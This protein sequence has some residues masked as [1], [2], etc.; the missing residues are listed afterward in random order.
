MI[1][2]AHHFQNFRGLFRPLI[3]EEITYMDD[4]FYEIFED[5]PR[6]GPGDRKS[7]KKALSMVAGLPE[8]PEI[9]DIGCGTGKQTIDLACLTGGRITAVDNHEPFLEKL[10]WDAVKSSRLAEIRT[11]KGDMTALDFPPER[12]D[13]IWSEGAAYIMGF[14][15]ALLAWRPLLRPK[16]SIAVSELVWFRKDPPDEVKN[17]FLIEYPA[18]KNFKEHF[19]TFEALGYELTGYFP[20]PDESWW[21]DYYRPMTKKLAELRM[22]HKDNLKAQEMYER[23]DTELDMHRKYSAYYG[24]GFYMMRRID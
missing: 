22:K 3:P 12:F 1:R 7:T 21:T 13:L 8:N 11:A 20:L 4:L 15:N 2:R 19:P 18:M 5:L 17:F 9:L 10:T 16:G 6:Q 24:Y 14:E 23:F